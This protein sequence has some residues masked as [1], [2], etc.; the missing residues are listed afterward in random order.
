MLKTSLLCSAIAATLAFSPAALANKANDTLIYASDSDLENISPYHNNMR[1]GVILSHHV[2][3]GLVLRDL[4]TGKYQPLLATAWKWVDPTTLE[5]ALRKDVKFHNGG[6]FTADDVV[7]TVNYVLSADAK[8]VTKQNVEW[9]AGA[10]KVDDFTVRIKLKEPFPAAMEYLAA[11]VPIYPKAYFEKVG[12]EGFAKAPVGTGPYKVVAATSGQGVK[13]VK[14]PA[15]MKDSPKGQP[16]IGKLEFK[17][18]PDGESRVAELMT[19][20]IDWIWRVPSDQADSLK[21]VPDVAVLSSETMRVAF[22]IFELHSDVPATKPFQDERVRKAVSMA[23]DRKAMVDNLVRGGSRVMDAACFIDQTMCVQDTVAK[24][25][26]DPAKAKAL[27]KEA[28]YPNGFETEIY[29]YRERDYAEA[30]IG[31]LQAV[32]IKAKLNFLKYP[33]M[34]NEMYAGKSPMTMNTWGSYSVNDASAFTGN[35][36]KGSPDDRSK[37]PDVIAWLKEADSTVDDAKRAEFY[38]KALKRISEK[39]YVLPLFSY[40]ANYAFT[41]DLNFTAQPD[42]L[43]RFYA[44]SWK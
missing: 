4:A 35:Y 39:A 36:F 17:V 23:I 41:K 10:E 40:S 13:M 33:A 15:Y 22:I 43:P 21:A 5:F 34:R 11:A 8:V 37:D 32:G 26:Y 7:F 27:L 6:A 31:Y 9:M 2:W 25:S 24:Y 29:A 16:K 12:L 44:A 28:G 42:E 18:I 14:N 3:D 19:G 20:G 38:G 30:M 1:E